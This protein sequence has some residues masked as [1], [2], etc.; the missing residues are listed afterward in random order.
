MDGSEY[1][2]DSTD[3]SETELYRHLGE[4]RT[5]YQLIY[6]MII[7]SSNLS[8]NTMI[9]LVDAKMSATMAASGNAQPAR[10]AGC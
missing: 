7:V 5:V 4:K 3:D 1:K 8:T 2:L 6:Q 10:T 9:E